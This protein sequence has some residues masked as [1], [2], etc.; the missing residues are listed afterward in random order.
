MLSISTAG[1]NRYLLHFSSYN[2]LTQW[3]SAI[4][5]AMF[6]N[7][8]LQEAY[9][10]SLIAGK[11]K[12]LNSIKSIMTK[13]VFKTEEWTR[14]RFGAGTPW[15]RCWCV[16]SPPDEKEIKSQV[17][18]AKKTSAY[19]KGNLVVKGD[20]KFYDTRKVTKKTKPVA[21]IRDA[22]STYAVYPQSRAL[23][24]QSTLIKIEG[25]ITIHSS[26][27]VTTEGF[28]FV[29]PEVH[30][31]VSGFEMM[32]RMLFPI[33]D[34]FHLYGRPTKL[35]ADTLDTR[36]LMFALP[37]ERRYGYLEIFDVG[38]LISTEGQGKWSE[39][40]WRKKMKNLVSERVSRAR[41]N[42]GNSRAT[43]RNRHRNSLPGAGSALRFADTE[44]MR[45]TP[46]LHN[47]IAFPP[48]NRTD[49]APPGDGKVFSRSH[50]RSVSETVQQSPQRRQGGG[51]QYTPSRLSHEQSRPQFEDRPAPPPHGVQ[52]PPYAAPMNTTANEYHRDSSSEDEQAYTEAHLPNNSNA[53]VPHDPVAP[54]PA[55][56]H[57]SQ[58]R[59]PTQPRAA[60]EL[61][62]ANSR[63]SS[64]TLSQ[65]AAANDPNARPLDDEVAGDRY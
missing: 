14:V 29:M 62:R 9:T 28:I 31:A 57:Q 10:G 8:C 44:S 11:G 22:Y 12:A 7:A 4:R 35:I 5:L 17:K 41:E 51:G 38:G 33:Y 15:R 13:T 27:E 30:P 63:M 18:A 46:S 47:Q 19:T 32:L 2:A 1:K 37:Q 65:L 26:P 39:R 6:E 3:T 25:V 59:P 55:F 48:P 64:T 16:I 24:D 43:S 58:S 34:V 50:N 52:P 54:P 56:A 23:I 36:G 53:G 45:S 42:G 60:P 40:E 61:R 20:I 21:T 49:S